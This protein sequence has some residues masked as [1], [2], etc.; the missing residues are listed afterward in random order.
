MLS[1]GTWSCLA[2]DREGNDPFEARTSRAMA[3]VVDT[4]NLPQPWIASYASTAESRR[5]RARPAVLTGS[6]A[7]TIIMVMAKKQPFALVYADEVKL[8]LHAIEPKYYPGIQ[9]EIEVQLIHEPDV[10]TRNRKPL[11]RPVSFGADWELR[12][13]PDN[14]FRVFYQVNAEGREVRILAVGVKKRNQL[15]IGGDE[16]TG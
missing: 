14:R 3:I 6:I 9:S 15:F 5:K 8:H 11:K 4:R 2:V 16:Y 13:G 1:V 12:L 10:E 7:V